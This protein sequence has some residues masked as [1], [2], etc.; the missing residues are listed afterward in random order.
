MHNGRDRREF[1]CAGAGAAS[2]SFQI[3]VDRFVP[4]NKNVDLRV[5]RQDVLDRMHNGRDRRGFICAGAGSPSGSF[6]I[7]S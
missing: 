7:E 4:G 3:E 1:I 2:G 6:H 5:G